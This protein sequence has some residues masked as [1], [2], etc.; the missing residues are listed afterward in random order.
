MNFAEDL[1]KIPSCEGQT[2]TVHQAF[3]EKRRFIPSYEGQTSK[4][5]SIFIKTLCDSSPHVRGRPRSAVV[6]GCSHRFIPS[7]EGQTRHTKL[8]PS[9]SPIHPLMRGADRE[10]E[11]KRLAEADSSPHARGRLCRKSCHR[12]HLRFIP[13]C[14]GQTLSVYAA[15]S[16][17]KHFVVQFTQMPFSSHRMLSP[18][19]LIC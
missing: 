10:E 3:I 4:T 1:R 17:L 2:F 19:H 15:F 6:Y 8:S 5:V 18:L 11:E 13:S 7:C 16:R 9:P 14:E 12:V